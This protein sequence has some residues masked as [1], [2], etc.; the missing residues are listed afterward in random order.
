MAAEAVAV[1]TALVLTPKALANRELVWFIDNESALSSLI[2]GGSK[3]EDVGHVAACTQLAMLEHS[4]AA[5]YEWIDSASNPA[6]G[7]SRDGIKDKW[8]LEQGW[9]LQELPP[10]AFKQ[11]AEYMSQEKVLRITGTVPITHNFAQ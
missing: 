3:A 2:R 10:E 6:D 4:C 8:T 5:W 9:E 1:L 11:V 7:L